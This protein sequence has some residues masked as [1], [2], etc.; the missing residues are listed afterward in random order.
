MAAEDQVK[1]RI[2]PL[3]ERIK[4]N[5]PS[6]K[7]S[8]HYS[9]LLPDELL[10]GLDWEKRHEKY[11]PDDVARLE[12]Q[13]EKIIDNIITNAPLVK[14]R[15]KRKYD[16]LSPY[17]PADFKNSIDQTLAGLKEYSK[18]KAIAASPIEK[19]L[20]LSP[21]LVA[22][23]TPEG[24]IQNVDDIIA[25]L[26]KEARPGFS[27]SDIGHVVGETAK[28][29]VREPLGRL[30]QA[31]ELMS[32]GPQA[33]TP[34]NAA[35]DAAKA[36]ADSPKGELPDP[37]SLVNKITD[38]PLVSLTEAMARGQKAYEETTG[39]YDILKPTAPL[40]PSVTGDVMRGGLEKIGEAF[41]WLNTKA[42]QGATHLFP[43]ATPEETDTRKKLIKDILN[44]GEAVAPLGAVGKL[45]KGGKAAKGVATV[46]K[47]AK[48]LSKL[49]ELEP[50]LKA[51]SEGQTIKDVVQ[52]AAEHPTAIK[53]RIKMLEGELAKGPEPLPVATEGAQELSRSALNQK[54]LE[55]ISAQAEEL[56]ALKA[57]S[58]PERVGAEV[59]PKAIGEGEVSLAAGD[60]PKAIAQSDSLLGRMA[61][62]IK[63]FFDPF[64]NLP[65]RQ[66]YEAERGAAQ[67]VKSSLQRVAQ[68]LLRDIQGVAPDGRR[69]IFQAIDNGD[70]S[71]LSASEL[72]VYNT[73]QATNDVLGESLVKRGYIPEAEF[74]GLRGH[75]MP[76]TYLDDFFKRQ[77]GAQGSSMGGGAQMDL[78][79]T[80]ARERLS[81]E[82]Q[83]QHGLIED[84]GVGFEKHLKDVGNIISSD[85]LLNAVVDNPKWVARDSFVRVGV[86]KEIVPLSQLPDMIARQREVVRSLPL[87]RR[88]PVEARLAELEKVY[89]SKKAQAIPPDFKLVP[90]TPG[91]GPLR[92]LHVHKA[93]A[94]DMVGFFTPA[95]ELSKDSSL[96]RGIAKAAS[97]TIAYWKVVKTVL[98]VP[99]WTRNFGEAAVRLNLSGV[100][101]GD[102][103]GLYKTALTEMKN[104]GP[105]FKE[106]QARGLLNT[107]FSD[108]ELRPANALIQGWLSDQP[109][110]FLGMTG[111]G[112]AAVYKTVDAMK[113][114]A[115]KAVNFASQVYQ[116]GDS[117]MVLSK[118]IAERKGGASAQAAFA[119][120]IPWAMDYS[121]ANPLIKGARQFALPFVSYPYKVAP[122]LVKALKEN[123]A[124][125]V[126]Y[127]MLPWVYTNALDR[128]NGDVTIDEARSVISMYPS[129]VSEMGSSLLLPTRTESGNLTVAPI[130]YFFP[131][132]PFTDAAAGIA[133]GDVRQTLKITAMGNPILD[134][135]SMI[136]NSRNGMM[137]DAFTGKQIY[138]PLDSTM[139]KVMKV[140]GKL[141]ENIAVP[142]FLSSSGA[143]GKALG[144]AFNTENAERKDLSWRDVALSMAGV[145]TR[146]LSAEFQRKLCG[147]AERDLQTAWHAY[148]HNTNEQGPAFEAK[149]QEYREALFLLKHPEAR[150]PG[151][152]EPAKYAESTRM[153]PG[154]NMMNP[155]DIIDELTNPKHADKFLY[156]LPPQEIF[157]TSP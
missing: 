47:S 127:Q 79:V 96:V 149:Q 33:A 99:S 11:H 90:D 118:Y 71:G 135:Y 110:D 61:A 68:P 76:H 12:A 67:G 93:I 140:T 4:F 48:E 29:L 55:K 85:N 137:F 83:L 21:E 60:S 148:A 22:N 19:A 13:R 97:N 43:G 9:P 41:D 101:F 45:G 30:K 113:Q 132:S 34:L 108:V 105:L 40:N 28:G 143:L 120:T 36:L 31:Y 75:Y 157:K 115:G 116:T 131:W 64:A 146:P 126:K 117:L 74:E 10:W 109:R 53:N 15:V 80:R 20:A 89:E 78:G 3:H 58:I 32:V 111:K 7:L 57:R 2:A 106:A 91:Y 77:E 152:V 95:T 26:A 6:I 88:A 17:L 18:Q 156:N 130:D 86:E 82:A 37:S 102:I 81:K 100:K 8:P 122:V 128:L 144:V 92:G 123:P 125:F 51:I 44:I 69:R 84:V 98:N 94:D 104:G 66:L 59:L 142:G 129:Y 136:A 42:A 114:G 124:A 62:P 141:G 65:D 24:V 5:H 14:Q 107:T 133:K 155:S 50:A 147:L 1:E 16:P 154:P 54:T 46:G 27:L 119:N 23:T 121:V 151:G 38:R 73:L 150:R 138:N 35:I 25:K 112:A 72:K 39:P 56:E 139:T 49:A 70:G 87:E 103:P 153:P 52:G 134:M 145:N 63:E